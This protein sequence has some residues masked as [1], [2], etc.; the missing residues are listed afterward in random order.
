M[1]EALAEA[2][3]A[4]GSHPAELGPSG[5]VSS[6]SQGAAHQAGDSQSNAHVTAAAGS[7]ALVGDQLSL[8]NAARLSQ[9][10]QATRAVAAEMAA[11]ADA[12]SLAKATQGEEHETHGSV[13]PSYVPG[14]GSPQRQA[15]VSMSSR[16]FER[17]RKASQVSAVQVQLQLAALNSSAKPTQGSAQQARR[18]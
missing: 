16:L 4:A 9:P 10:V 13:R 11:A 18:R 14:V 2:L 1:A 7:N 17:Q 3:A 15:A 6:S 8:H 5:R 12:A